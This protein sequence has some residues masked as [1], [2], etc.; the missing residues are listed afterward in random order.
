MDDKNFL[1]AIVLCV[2]V[3]AVWFGL[4]QPRMPGQPVAAR[5]Q[6]AVSSAAPSSATTAETGTSAPPSPISSKNLPKPMELKTPEAE[7]KISPLGASISSYR[8][9]GPLGFV[10]LVADPSPGIFSTWP[11][12]VF[13]PVVSAKQEY[14]ELSPQTEA[15]AMGGLHTLK[16]SPGFPAAAFEARLPSGLIVRKEFALPSAETLGVLRVT[17]RNPQKK[18]VSLSAWGLG[19]GPGLGTVPSEQGDNAKLWRAIGLFPPPPD[20]TVDALE[21]LKIGE[22]L[23][24]WRWLAIDNRYF[25]TA[26]IASPQDFDRADVESSLVD[27]KT[28]PGLRIW[29]KSASLSAGEIKTY[30]IPFYVGP[31]SY[32]ALERLHLGLERSVNF[33]W[34]DTLGRWALKLLQA[35]HRLTGNYG[36]SII[37]MTIMLQAALFPLTFKGLKSMAK[38]RG[39]QPEIARLQQKFK[40]DP[41]R[42]NAEMMEI[43]KSKGVNP[44]GGC[45]PMLAQMPVFVALFNALRNSWELHGAPWIL[46]VHDLSAHDPFYILPLLMGGVMFV[47]NRMNPAATADPTQAAMMNWMPI[48]FTFMFLKFPAGLVLYWLTNSLLSTLQQIALRKQLAA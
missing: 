5:P 9:R 14:L 11:D 24:P 7:I 25:L 33:G 28:A 26:A 46:W 23:A 37:L 43:Y 19:L 13:S 40:S 1:I 29:A 41:Q 47:Q 16:K 36:W 15:I 12:L 27:G 21:H 31:K 17:I 4:V 39:L 20:R 44:M 38:M 3:Y 32:T 48:I 45:L 10:E 42:L 30:D 22:H 6:N 35:L 8:Y 2:G 34:F 18:A